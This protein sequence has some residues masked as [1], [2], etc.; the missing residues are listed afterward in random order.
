[1]F[2]SGLIIMLWLII[3]KGASNKSDLSLSTS[4]EAEQSSQLSFSLQQRSCSP[5]YRM[6]GDKPKLLFI[7][8]FFKLNQY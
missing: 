7:S 3:S 8:D 1:M 6:R 4:S 2:T 5:K